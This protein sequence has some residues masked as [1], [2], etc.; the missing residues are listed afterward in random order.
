MRIGVDMGG[1]KIE[2]I[3]LDESG[4]ALARRRVPTPRGDY[5]ATVRTIRELVA[6]LESELDHRASVGVGI[7][8]A[9]LRPAAWSRMRIPPG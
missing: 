4:D 6:G 5:P 1:T 8:G 3:A 2:A 7:P 9:Y